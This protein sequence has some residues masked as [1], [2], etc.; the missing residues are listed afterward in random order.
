MNS[1]NSLIKEVSDKKTGVILKLSH[2][3]C[4]KSCSILLSHFYV[5]NVFINLF[6]NDIYLNTCYFVIKLFIFL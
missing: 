1:E 4:F 6:I 3:D 5:N 2:L